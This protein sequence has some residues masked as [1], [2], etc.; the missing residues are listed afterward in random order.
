MPWVYKAIFSIIENLNR[1]NYRINYIQLQSQFLIDPGLQ[2]SAPGDLGDAGRE[3]RWP[4]LS[5]FSE[6]ISSSCGGSMHPI[7]MPTAHEST[8]GGAGGYACKVK[9]TA[10][11]QARRPE[12]LSISKPLRV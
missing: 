12:I 6:N 10:G 1:S 8:C 4:K 9:D 7:P 11:R 3:R 2:I 5:L